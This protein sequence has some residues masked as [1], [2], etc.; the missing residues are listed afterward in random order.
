MKRKGTTD[1]VRVRI[2]VEGKE[3]TIAWAGAT[4]P[5]GRFDVYKSTIQTLTKGEKVWTTVDSDGDG[6]FRHLRDINFALFRIGD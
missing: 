4:G 6:L 2:R 3:K 1:D 5:G